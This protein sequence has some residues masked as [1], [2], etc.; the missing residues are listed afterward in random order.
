[1]T[2]RH[3]LA[4]K[5]L[6]VI[7]NV[8]SYFFDVWVYKVSTI[9]PFIHNMTKQKCQRLTRN[10]EPG[11]SPSVGMIGFTIGVDSGKCLLEDVSL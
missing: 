7:C 6:V 1:M 5:I 9:Y 11:A 8:I 2:G 4:S 3:K 10:C